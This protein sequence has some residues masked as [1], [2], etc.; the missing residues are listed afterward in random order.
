MLI[1]NPSESKSEVVFRGVTYVIDAGKSIEV[2][3][4]AAQYLLN[5][6]EFLREG[7]ESDRATAP[8]AEKG[9][10]ENPLTR[11]EAVAEFGEEA[12][13]VAEAEAEEVEAPAPVKRGRGKT[14]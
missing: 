1:K 2:S 7:E 6:H 13:E 5:T 11:D 14:K 12:V 9:S 4:D 8:V 10:E 3:E